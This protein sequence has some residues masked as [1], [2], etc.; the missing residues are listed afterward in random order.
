MSKCTPKYSHTTD[1]NPVGTLLSVPFFVIAI[2]GNMV[3]AGVMLFILA[4]VLFPIICIITV[5]H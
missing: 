5:F 1:V 3:A 4:L 2:L